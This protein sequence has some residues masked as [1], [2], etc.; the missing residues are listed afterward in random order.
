M[1]S[2][3]TPPHNSLTFWPRQKS[4]S[5]AFLLMCKS[6]W[7]VAWGQNS[8]FVTLLVTNRK[9]QLS[10]WPWNSTAFPMITLKGKKKKTL[11]DSRNS[12]FCVFGLRR[13]LLK[14]AATCRIFYV[15][16]DERIEFKTLLDFHLP[17]TICSHRSSLFSRRIYI[18]CLLS[19]RELYTL[20]V[21][22]CMGKSLFPSAT[23]SCYVSNPIVHR[24]RSF[25][26]PKSPIS[27]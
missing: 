15:F 4:K 8:A 11:G 26:A 13:R 5:R 25:L 2:M 20:L 19:P 21:Y 17:F 16:A 18:G 12:F 27:F 6:Y 10:Y 24:R 1:I 14:V 23:M 22:L 7:K 9:F 3:R